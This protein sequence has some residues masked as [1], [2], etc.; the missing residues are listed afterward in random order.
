[1]PTLLANE[2]ANVALTAGEVLSVSVLRSGSCTVV[3]RLGTQIV[4]TDRV[5]FFQ[6][7][8]PYLNDQVMQISTTSGYIDYSVTLVDTS[9]GSRA[10]VQTQPVL[11]V[12]GDS[13][14]RLGIAGSVGT[15]NAYESSRS[16]QGWL[17][18]L[19]G[20]PFYSPAGS[21]ASLVDSVLGYNFGVSGDTVVNM[22][23]RFSEVVAKNPRPTICTIL[24]GTND[25]KVGNSDTAMQSAFLN[26]FAQARAAGIYM[27]VIPILPRNAVDGLASVDFT[28]AERLQM[29][30]INSWLAA[31]CQQ[32]GGAARFADPRPFLT[33]QADATGS[34]VAGGTV[35]G[36]H[37]SVRGCY[38]MAKALQAAMADLID[39]GSPDEFVNSADLWD[40]TSNPY[41]NMLLNPN[42]TGTG[43]TAS[44]PVTGTVPTDWRCER[45][46]GAN[47]T[48]TIAP[49]TK[50]VGLVTLNGV[51]ITLSS[52]GGGAVATAETIRFRP[53]AT[54][55]IP[56]GRTRANAWYEGGCRIEVDAPSTAGLI[57]NVQLLCQDDSAGGATVRALD[58]RSSTSVVYPYPDEA[59]TGKLRTCPILTTGT[60]NMRYQ[61]FFGLDTTKTGTAVVRI[62][63][64]YFREL[65]T[66][67]FR[68]LT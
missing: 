39:S 63:L 49:V 7:F 29:N 17:Q 56:T 34:M 12:F 4:S 36:V 38:Y 43:G 13:I 55:N 58:D 47:I 11:A 10:R 19:S 6:S 57:R 44:A 22:Q 65:R 14:T 1:M 45:A 28:A 37:P 40:A 61:F 51:A 48:A 52:P 50:T 20:Y 59:W 21:D 9:A 53:S 23:N 24:A 31:Y 8:G 25:V 18:I 41:G 26:I 27:V 46:T 30:R 33:S 54:A 68:Y 3:R 64:P 66:V 32:S 2:T 16:F 15:R 60:G 42:M 35:D 62:F 5:T 67:P